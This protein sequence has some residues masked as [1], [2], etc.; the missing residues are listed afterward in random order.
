[1][2]ILLFRE[3][4]NK[5]F[6]ILEEGIWFDKWYYEQEGEVSY[7][8]ICRMTNE[9]L[10]R[11]FDSVYEAGYCMGHADGYHEATVDNLPLDDSFSEEE[12]K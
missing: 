3:N 12:D 10:K 4:Y 5:N 9:E 1:M 6:K 11:L 2:G 8:K 7:D